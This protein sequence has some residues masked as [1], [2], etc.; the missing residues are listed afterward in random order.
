MIYR[1]ASAVYLWVEAFEQ[2]CGRPHCPV[3]PRRF[4]R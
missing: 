3:L 4:A 1:G 2:L